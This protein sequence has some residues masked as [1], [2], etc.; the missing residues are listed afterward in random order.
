MKK[1]DEDAP[2]LD[3]RSIVRAVS[4]QPPSIKGA[5]EV[6]AA[7]LMARRMKMDEVTVAAFAQVLHAQARVGEESEKEMQQAA[8]QW[9]LSF[10]GWQI[11]MIDQ[12]LNKDVSDEEFGALLLA[13]PP[14]V[15]RFYQLLRRIQLD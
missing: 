1:V 13:A 12:M 8:A 10:M 3:F 5:F 7:L 2:P 15:A 11:D 14:D 9:Y 4:E 6:A